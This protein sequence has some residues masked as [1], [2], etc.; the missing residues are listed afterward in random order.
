[1]FNL[2]VFFS[3]EI[4]GFFS[5]FTI[6][7]SILVLIPSCSEFGFRFVCCYPIIQNSGFNSRVDSL[8][9]LWRFSTLHNNQPCTSVVT[10]VYFLRLLPIHNAP[11]V[12]R[13]A[14]VRAWCPLDGG[15]ECRRE[16]M[17]G[18]GGRR[19]RARGEDWAG[20]ERRWREG[21]PRGAVMARS[22]GQAG[23]CRRRLRACGPPWAS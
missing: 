6:R 3:F 12:W 22:G 10:G 15:T 4:R 23:G 20:E 8:F 17:N 13:K 19:A 21:R 2:R 1:M 7:V 5:M 18:R 16:A 14:M 11:G 9:L